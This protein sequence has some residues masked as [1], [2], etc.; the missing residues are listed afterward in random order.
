MTLRAK[1]ADA[2]ET[3]MSVVTD[4]TP[5]IVAA[6][7]ALS[8]GY[9][10]HAHDRPM[11]LVIVVA[12]AVELAGVLAGHTLTE[13]REYNADKEGKARRH[14]WPIRT[15][16]FAYVLVGCFLSVLLDREDVIRWWPVLLPT[17]AVM[18]YWVNGER[19]VIRHLSTPRIALDTPAVVPVHPLII[20]HPNAPPAPPVAFTPVKAE[21]PPIVETVDMVETSVDADN[22][23]AIDVKLLDL[24]TDNPGLSR[25]KAGE[26]VGLS[27]QTVYN[28][29]VKLQA[30]GYIGNI[31]G[32]VEVLA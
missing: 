32:T 24:Y 29:L 22:L 28:R 5:W 1:S 4:W 6:A 14:L 16:L 2:S 8:I 3:V 19:V 15:A 13:A 27:R 25:V 7:P 9:S 10:L 30:A 11:P 26:A 31:N 17:L 20:A 18:V 12:L 21:A 23:D